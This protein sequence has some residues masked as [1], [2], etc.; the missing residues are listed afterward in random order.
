MHLHCL[1]L[2]LFD[3]TPMPVYNPAQRPNLCHTLHQYII[4]R[5]HILVQRIFYI[6]QVLLYNFAQL[7]NR[8]DIYHPKKIERVFFLVQ[9]LFVTNTLIACNPFHL[10]NQCHTIILIVPVLLH[11]HNLLIFQDIFLIYRILW[12]DRLYLLN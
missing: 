3:T 11:C 9:R 2:R 5:P 8:F 7:L 4:E 6:I 12:R 10:I 1:V